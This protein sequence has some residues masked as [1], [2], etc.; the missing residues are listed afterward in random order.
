[1][2]DVQVVSVPDDLTDHYN[3]MNRLVSAG[4]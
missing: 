2:N 1:M 4:I 3:S